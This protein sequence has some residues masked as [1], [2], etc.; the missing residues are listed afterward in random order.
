MG[1][2]GESELV[3]PDQSKSHRGPNIYLSIA[4]GSLIGRLVRQTAF[5]DPKDRALR[6][7]I[8]AKIKAA[9]ESDPKFRLPHE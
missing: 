2:R 9:E 3:M 6:D 4:E 5:L 7:E 8:L 1:P